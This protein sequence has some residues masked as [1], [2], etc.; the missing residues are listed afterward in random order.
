PNGAPQDDLRLTLAPDAAALH[1]A[2]DDVSV[3]DVA[4]FWR[5]AAG[6]Q[7][8][9][10]LRAELESNFRGLLGALA[11]PGLADPQRTPRLWLVT[12]RAQWLPGDRAD[13]TEQL[14]AAALWGFGHVLLNEHPK[15]KATL[16]DVDQDGPGSARAL[17]A[18]WRAPESEEYQIAYRAG[19]RHVRRLLADDG[20]LAHCATVELHTTLAGTPRAVP[21]PAPAL[22][23]DEVRVRV[24]AAALT[25]QDLPA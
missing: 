23:G 25:G 20:P 2:L 10:R 22:Q 11:A 3:T 21:V 8:Y 13:G 6:E 17:L 5:P 4:W 24:S 1:A 18:E 15:L 16:V 19:R 7:S 12:E 9:A 14:A